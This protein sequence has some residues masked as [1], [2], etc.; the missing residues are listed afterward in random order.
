MQSL[1]STLSH[2]KRRGEGK[3]AHTHEREEERKA[4]RGIKITPAGLVLA[5]AKG[6]EQQ[7]LE[8][9][10]EKRDNSA[11]S[12]ANRPPLGP[13]RGCPYSTITRHPSPLARTP[14]EL[15]SHKM[16]AARILLLGERGGARGKHILVCV[17]VLFVNA[18]LYV[19]V[20]SIYILLRN[21]KRLANG[22]VRPG[23][24]FLSVTSQIAPRSSVVILV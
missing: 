22:R 4:H 13:G 11:S 19:L 18:Y 12:Q 2:R 17:W 10:S 20:L 21:S 14:A 24:Y 8:P 5:A 9:P 3:N 1:D 16:A 7:R 6:T 23:T 15:A